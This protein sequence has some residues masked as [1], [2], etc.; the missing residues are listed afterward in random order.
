ME[1]PDAGFGRNQFRMRDPRSD[2]LCLTGPR[3]CCSADVP[4]TPVATLQHNPPEPP[5]ARGRWSLAEP[6]RQGLGE[7]GADS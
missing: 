1:N 7:W 5:G 3:H 6:G 2:R 4:P